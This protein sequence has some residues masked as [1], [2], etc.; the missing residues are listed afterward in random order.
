MKYT[1]LTLSL[2]T[3]GLFAPFTAHAGDATLAEALFRDG[4]ALMDS[5]DLQHACPKL[6]ESFTQDPATGTLL[7]L[8]L[9]FEKSGKLASAWSTYS[10]VAS[11][12]HQE[13]RADREQAARERVSALEP[14]LSKLIVQV[15]PEVANL[16]GLVVKR[17]GQQT[18]NAVWGSALPADAGAHTIDVS[19][20]GK[21][22]W[23]ADVTLG[24]E[25]DAKTVA[26]PALEDAPA[27]PQSASP[28]GATASATPNPSESPASSPSSA[29]SSPLR[30]IGLVAGG[31]GVVGIGIGAVFGLKAKSANTSSKANGHCDA[32]G[33]DATGKSLRNDAFSDAG[34][35]TALFI[36]GGVLVAG[37]VTLY[38]VGG[39]KSE[40]SAATLALTP[41]ASNTGAG[42]WLHGGF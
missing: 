24:A 12:S 11:R 16:S 40:T 21:K 13:G 4:K 28:L 36:A 20:D 25:N 30:P 35:S 38:L 7:A 5:G 26:V 42:L 10:Q 2:A 27:A 15:P 18:N 29:S 37:G 41:S 19:A 1:T 8:A 3:L 34:I 9:C 33:C 31:L 32:T 23:H 22:P 14:R 17:D 6:S 39:K